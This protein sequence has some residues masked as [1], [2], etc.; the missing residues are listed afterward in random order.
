MF[1]EESALISGTS[2]MQIS[3][4]PTLHKS[5]ETTTATSGSTE[6][7]AVAAA[8]QMSELTRLVSLTY[9]LIPFI[10]LAF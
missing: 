2:R 9:N 4:A 5:G 8:G 7:Q 6:A 3:P 1:P 10:T